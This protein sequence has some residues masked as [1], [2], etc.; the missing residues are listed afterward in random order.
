MNRGEW[1][2]VGISR[3]DWQPS[4]CPGIEQGNLNSLYLFKSMGRVVTG[5]EQ[6]DQ[7]T[8]ALFLCVL[9]WGCRSRGNQLLFME[10]WEGL[11]WIWVL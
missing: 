3:E 6:Q 8:P 1:L 4:V 11:A 2:Q 7:T 5:K 9:E 10:H